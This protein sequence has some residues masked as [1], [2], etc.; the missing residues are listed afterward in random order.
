MRFANILSGL[1]ALL[2]APLPAPSAFGAPPV[3]AGQQ[4]PPP[5]RSE[6]S[7]G[8]PS[9]WRLVGRRP[10]QAATPMTPAPEGRT[11]MTPAPT[12]APGPFAFAPQTQTPPSPASR[13]KQALTSNPLTAA[14]GRGPSQPPVQPSDA[15]SLNRA[16]PS[17]SADMLLSMAGIAEQSGDITA[18]RGLFQKALAEQPTNVKALRAY[19]RLEDRQNRLAEAEK[20]YTQAVASSPQD[21]ALLNDLALCYAR[22][23][24]MQASLDT[25]EQAIRLRPAKALYRN[26]IAKVL[27]QQGDLPRATAHLAAVH[28][29]AIANYNVGQMLIA[30]G[31][32]GEAAPYFRRAVASDPSLE[33]ARAMLAQLDVS[34][35][36]EQVASRPEMPALGKPAPS[37]VEAGLPDAVQP[38]PV[39][40]ALPDAAPTGMPRVLPAVNR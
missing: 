40:P 18:A 1:L 25:L 11:P 13:L 10:A 36:A 31:R 26:N 17:P 14:I 24:K 12:I 9:L 35:A 8:L 7:W 3:F 30:S 37:A 21:P 6:T 39:L 29:P 27:V 23:D 33:P 28:G 15:L 5:A 22:Q 19:G 32:G 34:P 4:Q 2:L 20:L 16:T 38:Q